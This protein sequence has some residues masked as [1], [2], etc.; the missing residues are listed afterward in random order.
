MARR[1]R[2][3]RLRAFL[4]MT[5][6]RRSAGRVQHHHPFRPAAR[7]GA[8]GHPASLMYVHSLIVTLR[9]RWS[10]RAARDTPGQAETRT[11]EAGSLLGRGSARVTTRSEWGPTGDGVPRPLPSPAPCGPRRRM[12]ARPLAVGRLRCGREAGPAGGGRRLIRG[13]WQSGTVA[14]RCH[15]P[16][17]LDTDSKNSYRDGP[18]RP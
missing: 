16:K 13:H 2:G 7:L 12:E 3:G 1:S 9:L 10:H 17:F 4:L 5:S 18:A 6:P 15:T 8:A 14:F 11:G